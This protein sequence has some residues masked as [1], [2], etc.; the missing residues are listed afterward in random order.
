MTRLIEKIILAI[1]VVAFLAMNIL[2][3]SGQTEIRDKTSPQVTERITQKEAVALALDKVPGTVTEVETHL[4]KGAWV[5]EVEIQNDNTESEVKVDAKTGTVLAIEKEEISHDDREEEI[6]KEELQQLTKGPITEQ[7]AKDIAV[8]H[9]KGYATS[10]ETEKEN[11]ILVYEVEVIYNGDSVEVE[12]DANTG[13]VL[14]IEW[15][16][17]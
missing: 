4:I 10:V 5:Y 11:G 12:I 6:T 7:K 13:E 2:F 8:S 14:E 16:D 17:D 1:V 15:E 3:I 9:V